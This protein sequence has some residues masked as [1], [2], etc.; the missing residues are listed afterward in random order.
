MIRALEWIGIR[1]RWFLAIG[2]LAALFL[3]DIAAFL[4]PALPAFVVLMYF[5]AMVRIDL[6]SVIR[7]TLRPRRMAVIVMT[8]LALMIATPVILAK[9]AS[10]I[11]LGTEVTAS[12]VYIS[13]A[14]PLGSA[15]ALCLLLGLNAALALELTIVGSF[16]AP[17]LGPIITAYLLGEAVPIDPLDLSLRLAA[18][19]GTGAVLAILARPLI[20][21]EVIARK[22]HAFDGLGAVAMVLTVLPIFAGVTAEITTAPMLA[23]GVLGLVFA[24][25]IGVQLLTTPPLRRL[26]DDASAGAVGLIWGNRNAALYLAALPQSP[27]F[28]LFVALYQFPMYM[29]PLLLRFLYVKTHQNYS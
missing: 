3:Q 24:L 25:N 20:G 19:I 16:L 4:R 1:A 12:L 18:M 11:G 10:L 9:L 6:L 21:A 28:T 8:C 15:A 22:A 13:A 23:L 17:I 7:R 29:T 5:L 14:P 26:T 27:V 2:A